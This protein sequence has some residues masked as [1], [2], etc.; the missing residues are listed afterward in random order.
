M[1]KVR[2]PKTFEESNVGFM[3]LLSFLIALAL[4]VILLY[5]NLTPIFILHGLF[6]AVGFYSGT[7]VTIFSLHAIVS[8]IL[9]LRFHFAHRQFKMLAKSLLLID[10]LLPISFILLF[11]CALYIIEVTSIFFPFVPLMALGYIG[12]IAVL[13][14]FFGSRVYEWIRIKYV[15]ERTSLEV[16]E[17]HLCNAK[18]R[19]EKEYFEGASQEFHA[20][21]LMF[22]RLEDWSKTAENYWTAAE[23]LSK[24]PDP[25][26]GFGIAWLYALSASAYLLNGNYG[27]AEK[28]LELGKETLKKQ[29]IDKKVK[30]KVSLILDFLTA[31]QNKNLQQVNDTWKNLKRRMSKWR[32]PVT[33]ET[34]LLLERNFH[35]IKRW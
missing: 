4:Y 21:A 33:E 29:K 12:L 35:S 28:L 24:E 6:G 30:E 11:I 26:F 8:F 34:I 3:V 23:T 31:I 14:K 1:K 2:L 10:T 15:P 13:K 32:Y 16:A 17:K 27:K 7:L 25:D 18:A 5:L 22:L 19:L 20:A 9:A